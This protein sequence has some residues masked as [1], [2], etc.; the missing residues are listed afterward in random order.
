MLKN[1]ALVTACRV[2]VSHKMVLLQT[3]ILQ[4]RV[5]L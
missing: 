2:Y 4:G 5:H 3:I 1:C